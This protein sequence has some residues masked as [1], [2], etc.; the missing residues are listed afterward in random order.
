MT[1]ITIQSFIHLHFSIV[2]DVSAAY[3]YSVVCPPE[4]DPVYEDDTRCD[5]ILV[6][7]DEPATVTI[8]TAQSTETVTIQRQYK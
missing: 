6:A 1:S 4:Y 3:E 8:S 5:V 7:G 2:Q